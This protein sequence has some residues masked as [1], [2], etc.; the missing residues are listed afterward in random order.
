MTELET[1]V[2]TGR[3]ALLVG[4][5]V[6]LE[7]RIGACVYWVGAVAMLFLSSE[8]GDCAYRRHCGLSQQA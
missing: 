4:H 7:S 2:Q 5:Q 1:A 6:E 3:Q 8:P